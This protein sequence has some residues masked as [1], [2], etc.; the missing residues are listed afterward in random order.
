MD[1]LTAP[2]FDYVNPDYG[3]VWAKRVERLAKLRSDP[4]LLAASKQYY[5]DHIVD[6]ISDWGVT[7]DPRNTAFKR[8]IIMPF[9]LFPRQREMVEWVIRK[10]L[11][12]EDGI[13][14]KSRD[15]GA[16]WLAMATSASLC[17]FWENITIGFG[18]AKEEKVDRSGD[19]DCLF[20]KGRAFLQYLPREYKGSWTA[21]HNSAHMR[22]IFPGTESSITGEAGDNIGMGGRKSIYFVDE[23]AAVERPKRVDSNLIANTECRVEMS[24]VKGIANVFAERARGGLIDRFDFHYRADPRK[25]SLCR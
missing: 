17:L 18:S 11:K 21:K 20:Y 13:V 8:P 5:K 14:V 1:T 10:W 22:L 25:A 6:F 3:T 16:S 9:I 23:F 15:C 12:P 24:T 2:R 4:G 19:P 7:V